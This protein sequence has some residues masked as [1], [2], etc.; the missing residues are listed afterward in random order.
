M[1]A[2]SYYD[3]LGVSRNA[4]SEEIAAAKTAL[5]KVY[6]PDANIKNDVDTTALMQEI[7]EAYRV[8]SDSEQRKR[9]DR[10]M[11]GENTRVF[12]TFTVG[13]EN[14]EEDAVS[15]VTYW[16]TANRLHEVIGKSSILMKQE[17]QRKTL[18]QRLLFRNRKEEQREEERRRRQIEKLSE[19][20][21]HYIA[22]LK[23][24]GIPMEYW[25][26]DAMNW[27]LVRW[28]Q[29]QNMDYHILFSRYDAYIEETKSGTEKL[30]L[31]SRNRRFHNNLKRLLS[32]ALEA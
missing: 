11:F 26:P 27:M 9:Y 3:I 5:A 22:I 10:E 21:I 8:L 17:P 16:N 6:H 1:N 12:R 24:A 28:G 23:M 15:F 18:P 4:T 19:Q 32:Y 31:R 2:H 14:G 30:R 29:K 25:S 20:A 13:P 7:L